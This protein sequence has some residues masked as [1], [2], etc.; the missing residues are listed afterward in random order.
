[1][2]T[3]NV[4]D[5][6]N[7]FEGRIPHLY[8]C[9]GQEVTV[10]VG[11]AILTPNLG[12]QL[13]FL[14]LGGSPAPADQIVSDWEA[15][16]AAPVGLRADEYRRYTTLTLPDEAIDALLDS[17]I[18]AFTGQ[19]RAEFSAFEQYQEPAQEAIFDMAYNL[20]LSGLVKKFPSCTAAVRAQ[21]WT[22]A[23]LECH[24]TGI[25]EE[26]NTETVSLFNA[27]AVS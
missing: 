25:Q 1:M 2:N 27:S 19:I 6:L 23:A 16:K 10:G 26:R 21:D 5:R 3:A 13:P 7:R 12:A 18:A 17:D 24:R 8:L 20:G 4:K 22:R 14:L 11:H 15:V 9:T